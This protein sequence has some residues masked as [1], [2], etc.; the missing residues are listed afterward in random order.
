MLHNALRD[1]IFV[2]KV[3]AISVFFCSLVIV[4]TIFGLYVLFYSD[5]TEGIPAHSVLVHAIKIY[6]TN[7]NLAKIVDSVQENLECCGISSAA[8]GYRDWNLSYQFNCA[9]A[10]PQPEECAVAL[11][12]PLLPTMRSL[13]CWQ[14]TLKKR[15]QDLE[16]DIFTSGCL[17]PL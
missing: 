13:E 2:L 11:S 12:N 4:L 1:N 6:H 17:R 15:H 9:I 14:N 16:H 5:T 3:F 7:R 8:Q 10:N